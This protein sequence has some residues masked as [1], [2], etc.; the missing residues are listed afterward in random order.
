MDYKKKVKEAAATDRA[1]GVDRAEFL[2]NGP[3]RKRAVIEATRS[4]FLTIAVSFGGKE[5]VWIIKEGPSMRARM[6]EVD[7]SIVVPSGSET[8]LSLLASYLFQG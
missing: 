4:D 6:R 1:K 3:S 8:E 2:I 5:N 7:P